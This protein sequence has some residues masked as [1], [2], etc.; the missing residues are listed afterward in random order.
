MFGQP[1][2]VTGGKISGDGGIHKPSGQW[3][4]VCIPRL[5]ILLDGHDDDEEATEKFRRLRVPTLNLLLL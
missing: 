2:K 5:S 3:M 1:V 4:T